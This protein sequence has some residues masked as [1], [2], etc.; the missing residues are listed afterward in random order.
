MFY[1]VTDEYSTRALQRE[2]AAD[3][4]QEVG[5]QGV[6]APSAHLNMVRRLYFWSNV[7]EHRCKRIWGAMLR[8]SWVT[9]NR[10]WMCG[11]LTCGRPLTNFIGS[12]AS[13]QR[14]HWPPFSTLV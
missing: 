11:L 10:K 6:V 5:V 8:L 13:R 2:R 3:S 9:P 4:G 7:I 14:N 12:L 1:G